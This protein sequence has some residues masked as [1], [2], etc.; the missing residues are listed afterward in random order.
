MGAPA[1]PGAS[2]SVTDGIDPLTQRHEEPFI[3]SVGDVIDFDDREDL[4]D[5]SLRILWLLQSR[6]YTLREMEPAEKK[7]WKMNPRAIDF[8][9]RRERPHD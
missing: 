1:T 9:F 6:G 5:A 7:A 4:I 2:T 3:A 8:A